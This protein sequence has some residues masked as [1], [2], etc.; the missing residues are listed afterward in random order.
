MSKPTDE[1][2]AAVIATVM[3]RRGITPDNISGGK[4]KSKSAPQGF[5]E[6]VAEQVKLEGIQ[7]N[8]QSIETSIRTDWSRYRD[9]LAPLV[10]KH[11]TNV[12]K[13]DFP[14]DEPQ[15]TREPSKGDKVDY[16]DDDRPADAMVD[17]DDISDESISLDNVDK[18]DKSEVE[19]ML[20]AMEGRL[21]ALVEQRISDAM[22]GT[23]QRDNLD[24]YDIPPMP[25][26]DA[27]SEKMSKKTGKPSGRM[28]RGAKSDL[29]VRIDSELFTRL[30][31]DARR[32]FGGNMSRAVDYALWNFFGK[33]RLSFEVADTQGDD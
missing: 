10:D 20:E 2:K 24:N 28:F 22:A 13:V 25:P 21:T 4:G 15:A 32:L 11:L 23:T 26:K 19:T 16:I 18:I 30:E 33:P 17:K 7:W 9:R 14:G 5:W 3:R 27:V 31:A 29:R 1:Q 6:E 12:D 8:V